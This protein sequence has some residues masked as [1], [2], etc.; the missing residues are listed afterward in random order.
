SLADDYP[1]SFAVREEG[2]TGDI[3]PFGERV[4]EYRV[5]PPQRGRYEFGDIHVRLESGWRLATHQ[6]AVAARQ[7]VR[8]FPNLKGI[9]RYEAMSRQ[10]HL[11]EFGLR[12]S[13]RVGQGTEF[14]RLREYA[15]DDEY[16]QIDWK[17]TA[18]RRKPISRVYELEKSQNV[19]L[20]LDAGRMMAAKVGGLAKLDY[21]INAALMLAYVALSGGDK[22]GLTVFS[23]QVDAALPPQ[24]GRQQF[25]RCL[26]LLYA[27]QPEL[28][29]VN[30]KAA[31]QHIARHNKR[32]SLIVIFTDLLDEETSQELVEYIRLL[33]PTHLPLCVTLS[34]VNI[35]ALAETVPREPA[36]V[37]ARAAALELLHERKRL[38]DRLTQQGVLVLDRT[39]DAISVAVVNRYLELKARQVI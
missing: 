35:V 26:D 8:V 9:A 1:V 20:C 23:R 37:Y 3:P 27:V 4:F 14:E 17:A 22:V 11:W 13:R 5:T 33:R 19:L 12:P 7:E 2:L 30:Y 31:L 36:D 28:C 15:P 34:D 24:R 10:S 16:R 39:P 18:R 32:R 25:Y 29:Y 6:F 21:A 38:L